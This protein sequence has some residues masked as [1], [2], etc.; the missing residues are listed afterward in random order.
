M[1]MSRI[2]IILCVLFISAARARAV[3][4]P[5]L[6]GPT[7]QGVSA[8]KG[9][10]V[11]WSAAEGIRW[12]TEIPGESW[13][14][15]IVWGDR[16]F[17]TTCTEEGKSCCVLSLDAATGKVLWD[18]E[19]HR[20]VPGHK[21]DRN[22]YATPTPVTD[23]ERVHAVFGDGTYVTVDFAG[24]VVWTNREFP[25]QSEH[26]LG[27]SPILWEG[28]LIMAR[29]GSGDGKDE[30]AGW[31]VPWDKSF[32]LALDSKSGELR[33]KASRGL[34]RIAHVCPNV[35]TAPD[36]RVQVISGAGDVV[37]GFDA[38]TG[39]RIWTSKNVGEGVVPSIVLGEGLAFTASGFGGRES[40]KAFRL[41]GKG[42][43]GESN[44]A[45][46]QRKGMPKIPSYLYL[47]P[48]LYT[49]NE[50]GVAMCLQGTTGEIVWQSRIGGEHA[51][52]PV[53]A[54]GRIYFLSGE[55]ETTVIEAGPKFTVLARSALGEKV[56]ASMAVSRQRL[57]I[58]TA[59]NLCSI[60]D[61]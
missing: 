38:R 16:V 7:R 18:K 23:G 35:W 26:G 30:K 49:V 22:T 11:R 59:G 12:K 19:V 44:I 41:G 8:E 54:D 37:Q 51:A 2:S 13:S 31:Q 6:R 32:V 42:D 61:N 48:Y 47:A 55:G 34:S 29:D 20:Q 3:N 58:R 50:S 33:W 1:N 9:L 10:P 40:I 14:S 46:E 25:F 24:S 36:G 52:S 45:W 15:P 4:W 27:T 43:L 39:E 53:G 56:Q 28:L 57:F 17:L 60:G 21:N 5:W